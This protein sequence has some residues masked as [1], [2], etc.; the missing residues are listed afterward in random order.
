MDTTIN[1]MSTLE[2]A[3]IYL[4]EG[5]DIV[6]LHAPRLSTNGLQVCSCGNP[7]CAS[8]AK[9]P[10]SKIH[11]HGPASPIRTQEEFEAALEKLSSLGFNEDS[12]PNLGII[13]PPGV[14]VLDLDVP[15]GTRTEDGF[16]V[17]RDFV[18]SHP[19]WD[20]WEKVRVTPIE[21]SVGG[22]WHVYVKDVGATQP[23]LGIMASESS[24]ERLRG[25][26]WIPN[27]R[28]IVVAPSRGMIEHQA[29]WIL[30]PNFADRN[31]F[32]PLPKQ[33][34]ALIINSA[35][36]AN[37]QPGEMSIDMSQP[38]REITN[39]LGGKW[40][41]RFQAWADASVAGA[42]GDLAKAPEGNRNI[43]LFRQACRVNQLMLAG[44]ATEKSI[45][46]LHDTA[47]KLGLTEPEITATLAS[48]RQRAHDIPYV[49]VRKG[50]LSDMIAEAGEHGIEIR[51]HIGALGNER[52]DMLDPKS[53]EAA[54]GRIAAS[55]IDKRGSDITSLNPKQLLSDIIELMSNDPE[56]D[57]EQIERL[58]ATGAN[59]EHRAMP[60]DPLHFVAFRVRKS[61][62][63]AKTNAPEPVPVSE[64]VN[65]QP[66]APS[67]VA[68]TPAPAPV[69][70]PEPAP[71]PVPAPAA[72]A[73]A[74]GERG[75][76][77]PPKIVVP[78]VD[79]TKIPVKAASANGVQ[80]VDKTPMTP[81][82]TLSQIEEDLAK[83]L[84]NIKKLEQ[85]LVESG[86]SL[87]V[88]QKGIL[89]ELS[90]ELT[91]MLI[92][93]QETEL[94]PQSTPAA[95]AMGQ[96]VTNTDTKENTMNI[97][98]EKAGLLV[99][100]IG[101]TVHNQSNVTN[102][103]DKFRLAEGILEAFEASNRGITDALMTALDNR[104]GSNVTLD[105]TIDRE[106]VLI[107]A[108]TR[109]G[110]PDAMGRHGIR[111]TSI[112]TVAD[113][114]NLRT[115]DLDAVQPSDRKHIPPRYMDLG[116]GS[117][118]RPFGVVKK[119][120]EEEYPEIIKYAPTVA[121]FS[122]DE[123]RQKLAK[124]FLDSACIRYAPKGSQR[125]DFIAEWVEAIQCWGAYGGKEPVSFAYTE[126]DRGM[127]KLVPMNTIERTALRLDEGHYSGS[128]SSPWSD[129]EA[130]PALIE[131]I[132]DVSE[133][134]PAEIVAY[135]SVPNNMIS[136][137]ALLPEMEAQTRE[138]FERSLGIT[139]SQRPESF[140]EISQNMGIPLSTV[141][142]EVNRA[143][144]ELAMAFQE[145]S[146]EEAERRG[147][148]L[149][150]VASD[151]VSMSGEDTVDQLNA[152][153]VVS[154]LVEAVRKSPESYPSIS[155]EMSRYPSV[156][157]YIE[158]QTELV[159]QTLLGEALPQVSARVR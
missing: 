53:Y 150:Q 156:S 142:F 93:L 4:S 33:F 94:K 49:A 74:T 1:S 15:R 12:T 106:L 86:K 121:S 101:S 110:N 28:Q 82:A 111:N 134:D 91:G 61:L 96:G 35:G 108:I 97:T 80:K 70:P 46:S 45:D 122:T 16:Q 130:K 2:A 133:K 18:S 92:S 71:A 143:K 59:I 85:E 68:P 32:Q 155:K 104:D 17:F 107:D 102:W 56:L 31:S 131:L 112:Q 159:K 78:E 157:E 72:P 65:L 118:P 69:P 148:G 158:D 60:S 100:A 22:G 44:V 87:D 34:A 153:T 115:P 149:A 62:L 139:P 79:P 3:Q 36:T 132:A 135:E 48:A 6:F 27:G 137:E 55:I 11:P 152:K 20:G 129:D 109:I 43:M 50:F 24:K 42:I 51:T 125:E 63:V 47:L 88:E 140:E 138:V 90:S 116:F 95:S 147:V 37:I 83:S 67:Q 113:D 40:P 5:V 81:I 98:Y 75:R 128:S 126:A 64:P 84:S 124:E 25:I 117:R 119:Q 76:L 39:Q 141:K 41:G 14:A 30:A 52:S 89:D 10:I 66:V 136:P 146:L 9:H 23:A 151:I 38:L 123:S 54:I 21:K 145:F 57:A 13:L 7:D 114:L 19:T 154:R 120:A 127:K 58:A 99:K 8:P 105:D 103:D 77:I 29:Q 26:D 73:R 144:R